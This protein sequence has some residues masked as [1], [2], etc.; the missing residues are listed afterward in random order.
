MPPSARIAV[1][2]VVGLDLVG[3]PIT[4]LALLVV[5]LAVGDGLSRKR[6]HRAGR[7]AGAE[8]AKELTASQAQLALRFHSRALQ[9]LRARSLGQRESLCFDLDEQTP[10][11]TDM[12]VE[13]GS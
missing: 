13:I 4:R 2:A 1:D 5:A 9:S 7:R 8:H 10:D 3:F 6:F 11:N 12:A